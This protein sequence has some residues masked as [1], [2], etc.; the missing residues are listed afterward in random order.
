MEEKTEGPEATPHKPKLFR[1]RKDPLVSLPGIL[2]EMGKTYRGMRAGRI[3]E[4]TAQ[5]QI[6]VLDRMRAAVADMA[7]EKIEAQLERLGGGQATW[8]Y[9]DGHEITDRPAIEAH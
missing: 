2:R 6:W 3:D 7:L 8:L 4:T 1:R 9:Y 5:K